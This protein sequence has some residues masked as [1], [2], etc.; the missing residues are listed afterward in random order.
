VGIDG[1]TK[2]VSGAIGGGGSTIQV[3]RQQ[4]DDCRTDDHSSGQQHYGLE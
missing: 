4:C 3:G 1:G 2:T